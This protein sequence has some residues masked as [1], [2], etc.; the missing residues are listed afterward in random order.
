MDPNDAKQDFDS[1]ILQSLQALI[2]NSANSVYAFMTSAI[3]PRPIALVST[4]NNPEWTADKTESI[5]LAPFSYFN[6]VSSEPACIMLSFVNKDMKRSNSEAEKKDTIRN[7]EHYREFVVHGVTEANWEKVNQTSGDF[8][9]GVSE[10]AQV[11]W[12]VT[13]SQIIST[14]RITEATL[15]MECTLYKTLNIGEGTTGVTI[16]AIHAAEDV[17]DEKG[18]VDVEKYKP[19]GRLGGPQYA[20]VGKVLKAIR[21]KI[22]K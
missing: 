13:P 11:G 5:N 7:I 18:R 14:P 17:L 2:D 10:L 22:Q 9:Y 19:V 4:R 20:T 3:A 16:E 15:A 21:P 6:A 1:F 12:T 8:P